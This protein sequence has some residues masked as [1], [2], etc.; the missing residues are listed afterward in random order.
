MIVVRIWRIER[1]KSQF[2]Y[3]SN[4]LR[5]GGRSSRRGNSRLRN[6]MRIIIESGLIITLTSLISVITYVAG[7]NSIYATSDVVRLVNS[8]CF[9]PFADCIPFPSWFKISALPSTSLSLERGRNLRTSIRCTQPIQQRSPASLFLWEMPRVATRISVMRYRST[10]S[11][12]T[13]V[14]GSSI[15]RSRLT[16][17]SMTIIFMPWIQ[18]VS[19]V[20]TKGESIT[21]SSSA[22]SGVSLHSLCYNRRYNVY[23][24]YLFPIPSAPGARTT[25]RHLEGMFRLP[26]NISWR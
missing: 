12:R 2:V 20:T 25:A 10:T 26:H 7:S 22:S 15:L 24:I 19:W 14:G 3:Q 23:H 16:M 9:M 1:E 13:E 4:S 17:N 21:F 8:L 11:V 18:E 5:S 6:I